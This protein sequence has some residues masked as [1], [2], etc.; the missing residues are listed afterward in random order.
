VG[1]SGVGKSTVVALLSRHLL[2]ESGA[3]LVGNLDTREAT[4]A[5]VRSLVTVVDQ[6]TTLFS[7]TIAQNLRVARPGASDEELLEAIA[8]AGLSAD[9]RRMPVGLDTPVG[10]RGLSLSGGQVQRIAIARALLRDAPVVVLDEPTSQVDLESEALIVDALRTLRRD[11]T[12]VTIA[13]RASAIRDVDRVI[14][15]GGTP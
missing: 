12:V 15:I 7:G 11:R 14:E 5:S 13:H 8:A 6:Q 9:L 4:G 2:P 1:P 3:V 10:E